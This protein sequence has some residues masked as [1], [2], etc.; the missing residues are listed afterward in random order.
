[1]KGGMRMPPNREYQGVRG[2][3]IPASM[4]GGMRMPPNSQTPYRHGS[5]Y[6]ASMKGGMRMPPNRVPRI[7]IPEPLVLQ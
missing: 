7:A 2:L 5:G 4:K 3:G 6:R 1:M